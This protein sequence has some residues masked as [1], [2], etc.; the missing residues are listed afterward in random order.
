[1]IIEDI[2]YQS[3]KITK[4]RIDLYE[5]EVEFVHENRHVAK[6]VEVEQYLFIQPTKNMYQVLIKQIH[7]HV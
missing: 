4:P 1:M 7:F 5:V 2:S 6:L 3:G